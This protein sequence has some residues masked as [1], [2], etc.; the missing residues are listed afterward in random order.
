M[1]EFRCYRCKSAVTPR[2]ECACRDGI[3]LVHADCRDVLPMLEAGAVDLVLTDPQYGISQP[4]GD[5]AR[6]NS[7]GTR[8][9]DFFPGDHD[10]RGVWKVVRMTLNEACRL[11]SQN[12]SAYVWCGHKQFGHINRLFIRAGWTTRFVVWAKQCPAPAPPGSGWPAGAELCIYAFRKGRTWMPQAGEPPF[13]N[14]LQYDSYRHGKSGK[15]DHPTQKPTGLFVE[16]IE[17]SSRKGDLV[18]DFFAGSGTTGRA[19][20]DL[21][22]RCLMV[23]IEEKYCA[24]AAERL[25]QEVLFT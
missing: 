14:V 5:F 15:V 7:K 19:C 21:G 25:K 3:C 8:R 12:A 9:F 4:G 11:A 22:R 20:K 13:S 6:I 2:G 17:Y 23:E 18:L 24:I 1:T 16:L 10:S